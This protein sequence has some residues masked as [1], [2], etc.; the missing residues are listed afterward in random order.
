MRRLSLRRSSLGLARKRYTRPS[1]PTRSTCQCWSMRKSKGFTG[2]YAKTQGSAHQKPEKKLNCW[3]TCQCWSVGSPIGS[4][5][6]MQRQRMLH[7][8]LRK[9]WNA[10]TPSAGSTWVGPPANAGLWE[11]PGRSMEFMQKAFLS[12]PRKPRLSWRKVMSHSL[13]PMGQRVHVTS[14]Q[15]HLP[16]WSVRKSKGF[17]GIHIRALQ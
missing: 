2:I 10:G 14:H 4:V 16:G 5:E 12:C 9:S 8:T 15:V 17:N 13:H 11:S 6:L 3:P 1:L 7:T